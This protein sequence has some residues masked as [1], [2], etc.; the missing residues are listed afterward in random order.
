MSDDFERTE[1]HN[2]EAEAHVLGSMLITRDAIEAVQE[3]E[4]RP[5][6]FYRPAHGAL[7]RL[8][9]DLYRKDEPVNALSVNQ[10]IIRI[11]S[12]ARGL[13][14]VYLHKLISAVPVATN[15]GYAARI[16]REMGM[17]RR[18][19]RGCTTAI[20]MAYDPNT[21]AADAL[22]E[23]EAE[24]KHVMLFMDSRIRDLSTFGAFVDESDAEYDWL[25]PGVLERMDRVIVVA[26]EGAGKTTLARQVAVMLAAGVHPFDANR[27]IP[28]KRSLYIDLENPPP[29]IRRKARHLVN[30]G[31]DVPGWDE[32]RCWRFT[33]PGGLDLRKPADQQLLDRVIRESRA[34]L[35]CMGPLYK[36]FTDGGERAEQLNTQV[37][38]ILDGY[39]EKYGIA[40]WLE[41]HAPMEQGGHRSLRPL[42][43]GVWSRWPEFGLALRKANEPNAVHVERFR[44]DRDERAWPDLLRRGNP[45]PWHAHYDESYALDEHIA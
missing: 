17:K 25:I 5:D 33:R 29:L 12:E 40:L 7:Y 41:T 16:V 15:V 11:Q 24:M 8:M 13:D 26:S 21:T 38:K 43:S 28:P 23:A 6:D 32:D 45:W 35:V 36:A 2:I 42:G 1:P 10:E 34:E 44:G 14:G 22:A 30:H 3:Y 19:I 9:I 27:R 39:R 31:R 18:I 37:S 4:L 20:Q